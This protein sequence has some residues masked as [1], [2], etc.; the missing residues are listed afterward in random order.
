MGNL[1]TQDVTHCEPPK[2]KD[3]TGKG[4]EGDTDRAIQKRPI[5]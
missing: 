3:K 1:Y 5:G 2:K 4:S